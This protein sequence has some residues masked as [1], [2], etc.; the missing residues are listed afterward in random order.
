M[1]HVRRVKDDRVS[2]LEALAEL[3]MEDLQMWQPK[4]KNKQGQ[5]GKVANVQVVGKST[6]DKPQPVQTPQGNQTQRNWGQNRQQPQPQP[7]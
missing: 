7:S 2:A 3:S 6:Q 4:K 5:G 1:G